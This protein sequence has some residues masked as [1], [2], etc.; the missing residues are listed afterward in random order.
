MCAARYVMS[1][2]VMSCPVI[3][4]CVV[5]AIAALLKAVHHDPYNLKALMML[6]VSYT[7]DLEEVRQGKLQQARR[8]GQEHG[9]DTR[10][11]VDSATHGYGCWGWGNDGRCGVHTYMVFGMWHV[12]C[13]MLYDTS[14]CLLSVCSCSCPCP[15]PYVRNVR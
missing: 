15:C 13:C 1:C 11:S 14:W 3:S 10:T 6:G 8:E 7:N 9:G 4:C 5:R 12:A 2:H